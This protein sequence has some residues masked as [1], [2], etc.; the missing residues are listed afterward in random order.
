MSSYSPW[1]VGE[2]TR[3]CGCAGRLFE[4]ICTVFFIVVPECLA[5]N[6]SAP[7][8]QV[9]LSLTQLIT[10]GQLYHSRTEEDT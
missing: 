10:K 6:S 3:E 8:L 4:S 7:P 2:P 5:R 1:R 9:N